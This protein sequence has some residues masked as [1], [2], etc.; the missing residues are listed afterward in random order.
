MKSLAH[1]LLLCLT[2]RRASARRFCPAETSYTKH[3]G[4]YE[5]RTLTGYARE[6]TAVQ[7]ESDAAELPSGYGLAPDDADVVTNVVSPYSWSTQIVCFY[8]GSCY[9]GANYGTPGSQYPGGE[10]VESNMFGSYWYYSQPCSSVVMV[11]KQCDPGCCDPT[12]AEASATGDPHLK[13]VHGE[14]FDLMRQGKVVLINIPR[15]KP[16][17]DALLVVGADVR[18]LG[19]HCAELYFQRLNVTG[20]WADEAHAGGF[21]FDAQTFREARA[22]WAKFGPLEL[23]VVL[24]RTEK[25]IPYLNF[26]VKHLGAAGFDVGGLLGEDDH[27]EVATP[28]EQCHKIVSLS[29]P[30]SVAMASSA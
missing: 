5:Y 9:N 25:G 23:K 18:R 22:E 10:V 17:E 16:V 8:G 13:N 20:V 7:C 1:V 15:G 2:V 28:E 3:Y 11:R 26:L 6:G 24:G 21:A 29:A 30:A 12:T 14:R 4:G 19:G 27:S